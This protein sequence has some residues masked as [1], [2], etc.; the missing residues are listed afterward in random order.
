MVIALLTSRIVDNRPACT[1][2]ERECV[3]SSMRMST[4]A[5]WADI[6]SERRQSCEA[7]EGVDG[8]R[9]ESELAPR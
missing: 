1:E 5:S 4:V 2:N 9:A 6:L 7:K 3:G 8:G